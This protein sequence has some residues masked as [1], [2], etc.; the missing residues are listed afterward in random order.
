MSKVMLAIVTINL[1]LMGAARLPFPHHLPVAATQQAIGAQPTPTPS[2]TA[3]PELPSS[4]PSPAPAAIERAI[5]AATVTHCRNLAGANFRTVPSL[6]NTAIADVIPCNAA[7]VL[8]GNRIH[9]DGEVWLETEWNGQRGW[10]AQVMLTLPQ[11]I[12][13]QMQPPT[14]EQ[15]LPEK[16][17]SNLVQVRYGL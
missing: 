15:P 3:T 16:T 11:Q 9:S 12:T 7:V 4:I 5:L 2:P 14:R 13:I 1:G 17:Q 6:D 10:V 8:T